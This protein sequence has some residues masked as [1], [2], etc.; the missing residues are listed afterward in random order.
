MFPS[1]FI[2]F[3]LFVCVLIVFTFKIKNPI[4]RWSAIIFPPLCLI[5]IIFIP[6]DMPTIMIWLLG[7]LVALISGR[8][9]LLRIIRFA[10]L[11]KAK[12]EER[13]EQKNRLV[14][15]VLTVVIFC[16]AIICVKVSLKS[17]DNYAIETGKKNS[18]NL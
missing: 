4:F 17:A 5:P 3:L 10:K 1:F 18:C 6:I 9:I 2:I 12:T 16:L 15:P 11:G 7:F 13:Y 14:R 8:S